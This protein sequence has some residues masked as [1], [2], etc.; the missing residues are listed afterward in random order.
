[1]NGL[2]KLS[3]KDLIKGLIVTTLAAL[4]YGLITLLP[5][6]N[7]PPL[8]NTLISTILGYLAK[9]LATDNEDKIL[10]KL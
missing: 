9:N 7:L 10:G 4:F 2:F 3:T 1:M 8:A 5:S 6:L